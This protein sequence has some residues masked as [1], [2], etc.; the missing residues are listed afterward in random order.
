MRIRGQLG[1]AAHVVLG[2]RLLDEQQVERVEPREVAR[3][4]EGVGGVGVDLQQDRRRTG[5]RTA[6]T[7][8]MSQPGS[9]FSLMRT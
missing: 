5:S 3:V 6:A 4:A 2:E 8:S 1:V 7:G 9:I